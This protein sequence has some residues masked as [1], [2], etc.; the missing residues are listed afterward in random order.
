M[1]S[2]GGPSNFTVADDPDVDFAE[3]GPVTTQ[4]LKRIKK[5]SAAALHRNWVKIPHVTFFEKSDITGLEAFRQEHKT[6][7]EKK[8][9]KL[10]PLAFIIKAVANALIDFPNINAS[11]SADGQNLVMKGYV[12]V[13]FA[14]DTP[15][16]LMVPVIR[17]ADKKGLMQ[18]AQEIAEFSKKCKEGTIK[19]KEMQGGCF[20][21]S[22][23]G[24][25]GT[26]GFTPIINMPELGI[27]GVSKAVIEPWYDGK[28]F[29]PRLMLPLSLSVD[30]RV[31]DG[32]EG[33]QFIVTVAKLLSDIR[34]LIM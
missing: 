30:H 5:L 31:I 34:Q 7:A 27:L 25:L 32:A 33:A 19:G 11:L 18:I 16:G 10:T 24:N 12:H 14:V 15:H 8:G 26:L 1:Q 22:S 23:I 3:Y 28:N 4:E 13:G 17:D 20:T 21:I 29:V 6:T 9:V 2:G